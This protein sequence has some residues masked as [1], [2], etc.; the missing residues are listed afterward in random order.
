MCF[1]LF[2]TSG[3]V[4]GLCTPASPQTHVVCYTKMLPQLQ[5]HQVTTLIKYSVCLHWNVILQ[6]DATWLTEFASRPCLN[7]ETDLGYNRTLTN[8]ETP[9]S[10]LV[11]FQK[12]RNND[13]AYE[14][15]SIVPA[16]EVSNKNGLCTHTSAS[17]QSKSPS[18]PRCLEKLLSRQTQ[19]VG[20]PTPD[21]RSKEPR[22]M[23]TRV[24]RHLIPGRNCYRFLLLCSVVSSNIFP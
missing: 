20:H 7:E 15:L 1:T 14:E 10:A 3:S 19:V 4:V 11:H 17:T 5:C 24:E 8:K 9:L 6:H 23:G 13:R 16:L 22:N 21:V 18:L 12:I 2:F